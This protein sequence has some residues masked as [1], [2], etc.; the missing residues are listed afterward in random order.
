MRSGVHA[1]KDICHLLLDFERAE[2]VSSREVA[3]TTD[4]E[5]Y[6]MVLSAMNVHGDSDETS[7]GTYTE[8]CVKVGLVLK[9]IVNLENVDEDNACDA[10][11]ERWWSAT[12]K[13]MDPD[14]VKEQIF[15]VD[16]S[17]TVQHVG[18]GSL[19]NPIEDATIEDAGDVEYFTLVDHEVFQY[20]HNTEYFCDTPL[21]M[22][23]LLQ[24][25]RPGQ[26]CG[27]S[28]YAFFLQEVARGCDL[29]QVLDTLRGVCEERGSPLSKSMAA[30]SIEM[31]GMVGTKFTKGR[32][33]ES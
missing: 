31:C 16:E 32:S 21:D 33:S 7:V 3:Q 28:A 23:I 11:D 2:A 17:G 10:F 4:Y 15:R 6:C 13:S 22:M 27:F 18:S 29:S 26:A 9:N 25:L 24:S 1:G 30:K 19:R 14:V 20:S 8:K 5:K 12:V